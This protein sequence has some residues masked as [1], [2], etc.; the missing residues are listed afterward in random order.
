MGDVPFATGAGAGVV[1]GAGWT[2]KAVGAAVGAGWFAFSLVTSSLRLSAIDPARSYV[3]TNLD[4]SRQETVAGQSLRQNGLTVSLDKQPDSAV[5]RYK[6]HG[7]AGPPPG[8][9]AAAT[10][11]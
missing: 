7:A 2:T 1:V 5:L 10:G 8:V 4:D 3:F 11:E 9:S 6:V